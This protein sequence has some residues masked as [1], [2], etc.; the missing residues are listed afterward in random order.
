MMHFFVN[1]RYLIGLVFCGLLCS[2]Q[3][4]AEPK[5]EINDSLKI[6]DWIHYDLHDDGIVGA[7]INK[8]Y[9]LLEGRPSKTVLVA[10]IDSGFDLDHEDLKDN[11]WINEGE[12]PDNGLDDDKN[13]YI[14][15]VCG[16]NF[17]GGIENNVVF[18]SYELTRE[19]KRLS[20]KYGVKEGSGDEYEY[21]LN[22]KEEFENMRGYAET[23]Y[24]RYKEY[25]D[26]LER[27]YRLMEN[28]LDADTLKYEEITAIESD[29]PIIKKA[30]SIISK[31]LKVYGDGAP[32]EK[33][34][35]LLEKSMDHYSYE[36]EYG[37][38]LD[39][40]P[41]GV[42][43][44]HYD[45]KKEK[46][47]GNNLA[48]D[49]SGSMGGHGTHVAGIIAANRD[50]HIGARGIADNV[51][52]IPIRTVP[53]G[54]ERDKD[55]ANAI[56]YAVNNG[57]RVI[58]MSFGKHYSPDRIIVEKAIKY[59]EKKGVLIVHAAGN[60]SENKDV[61]IN[62][63]T[64]QYLKGSKIAG[65]MIEVAAN[66]SEPDE[67]LPARFT[68]YGKETVDFFAPGVSVYSTM[69]GNTYKASSGTSMA[70]PVVSGVAA[71]LMSYFPE[72]SA[73]QV[74]D[75]LIQSV[76]KIDGEVIVP[77]TME[78]A[79]FSDLT[80]TGGVVNAYEAVKIAQNMQKLHTR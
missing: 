77:G 25:V 76:Q 28:Y 75:V 61:I 4:Y 5:P 18:D 12:I 55:V 15:D 54:D 50:N 67:S 48:S 9:Q 13:G 51:R 45:N 38:N 66:A 17:I 19:Y 65:N 16:W 39:F 32:P 41:R 59:A 3:V 47:Y 58:N 6:Q 2:F 43:N 73:N 1:S 64:R 71:M 24:T 68:N 7:S 63:P 37:Y 10:V 27:Y 34:K 74:K 42:V 14:D 23:S 44:D 49:F 69:P 70:A 62:F 46:Y 20:E 60:D 35:S 40:D 26:N 80:I 56:Y 72:L 11:Y 78:K 29:D 30:S 53:N 22:I 52:I 36:L 33:M 21:W 79:S 31:L 57:A 8:A